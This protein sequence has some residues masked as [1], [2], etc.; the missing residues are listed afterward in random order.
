VQHESSPPEDD[1][2][3]A[4]DMAHANGA[5]TPGN[6]GAVAHLEPAV[7]VEAPPVDAPAPTSTH[8]VL[9]FFLHE[10]DDEDADRARVASLIDLL[11]QHP[12]ADTVRLFVHTREDDRIELSMPDARASEDLR[13]AAAALLAPHGGVDDA[14]TNGAR[15]RRTHGIEPLEVV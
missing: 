3:F 12:G 6:G 5:G 4:H 14:Q 2:P 9:R 15:A 13:V 1:D 11:A 7:A 10:S 8:S